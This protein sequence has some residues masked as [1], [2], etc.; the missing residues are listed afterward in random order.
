VLCNFVRECIQ[1]DVIKQNDDLSL[2]MMLEFATNSLMSSGQRHCNEL[3][4]DSVATQEERL[5][6]VTSDITRH[7]YNVDICLVRS[8]RTVMIQD[9]VS[10]LLVACLSTMCEMPAS[11]PTVTSCVHHD[12]P[13]QPLRYTA[14]GTRCAPLL[15]CL[16]RLSLVHPPWMVK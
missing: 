6:N 15:D 11:C 13:C 1:I 9:A 16:G 5:S 10:S 8:T 14:F 2:K 7:L 3:R 12:R 4:T